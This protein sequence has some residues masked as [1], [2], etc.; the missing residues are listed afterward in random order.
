MAHAVYTQS[1]IGPKSNKTLASLSHFGTLQF[2]G[3]ATNPSA[4]EISGTRTANGWKGGAP[5]LTSSN[6]SF[7]SF[8]DTPIRVFFARYSV[9]T[10]SLQVPI[11]SNGV[12]A[13]TK[14]V[15]LVSLPPLSNRR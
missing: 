6:L 13:V 5:R 8:L 7:F 10:M 3:A 1:L 11:R 9:A 12:Q 14:A 15:I 4:P 2:S